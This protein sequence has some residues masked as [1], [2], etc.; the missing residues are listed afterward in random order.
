MPDRTRSD[1]LW[2]VL[3]IQAPS[4]ADC[5]EVL[6]EMADSPPDN[7]DEAVL[8]DVYRHVAKRLRTG[9]PAEGADI[10]D[11]EALLHLPLW[12]GSQWERKRPIYAV[13]D[14]ALTLA[15]AAKLRTWHS[16]AS[17]ASLGALPQTAQECIS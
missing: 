14:P 11:R 7:H 2:E 13:D 15:L 4:I 5:V 10:A 8:I 17:L 12:D 9:Q 3:N 16:P 6:T 1:H